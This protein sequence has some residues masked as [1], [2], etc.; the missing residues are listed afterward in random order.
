MCSVAGEPPGGLAAGPE[1][2]PT[3]AHEG[4]APRVLDRLGGPIHI[5]LRP[6]KVMRCRELDPED[7]RDGCVLKPWKRLE[8][9]EEL[10]VAQQNPEAVS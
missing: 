10:T 9:K 7:A 2:G 4:K 8:R 3:L 1:V 5:K 6:V